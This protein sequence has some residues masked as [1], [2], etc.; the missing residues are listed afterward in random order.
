MLPN[1]TPCQNVFI[2]PLPRVGSPSPP[3]SPGSSKSSDT[4]IDIKAPVVDKLIFEVSSA[5]PVQK[6]FCAVTDVVGWLSEGTT[7]SIGP[8]T[9]DTVDLASQKIG[10]EKGEDIG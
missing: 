3:S 2:F 7:K 8:V 4:L 1:V 6:Q 5:K 10:F 9:S